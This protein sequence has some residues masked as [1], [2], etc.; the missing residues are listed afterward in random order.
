M[1]PEGFPKASVLE[2]YA[3]DFRW[4]A[5]SKLLQIWN[6]RSPLPHEERLAAREFGLRTWKDCLRTYTARSLTKERDKLVAISGASKRIQQLL[7]CDYLAGLWMC[8]FA[9]QLLWQRGYRIPLP[10]PPTMYRAPSWSWASVNCDIYYDSSFS[11]SQLDETLLIQIVEV[12]LG[13]ATADAY[14]QITGGHMLLKGWR[15]GFPLERSRRDD[16]TW[17][18]KIGSEIAAFVWAD[19]LH[20]AKSHK[21]ICVPVIASTPKIPIE[22]QGGCVEGLVLSETGEPGVYHRVG[23]FTSN[24]ERYGKIYPRG[25]FDVFNRPVY[26]K[27]TTDFKTTLLP[28]AVSQETLSRE[29]MSLGE[30]Y[31]SGTRDLGPEAADSPKMRNLGPRSAKI[32]AEWPIYQVDAEND[33]WVES[34]MK[35]I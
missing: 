17:M 6:N 9:P 11:R 14:G 32:P 29:G 3:L 8:D 5:D 22:G 2:S 21:W 18:F 12:N 4:S 19:P 7:Q 1:Y 30:V 23:T 26:P 24:D 15:R 13:L 31:S 20:E 34:V 35:I 27:P 25:Y 10:D 33:E 28:Y 16:R